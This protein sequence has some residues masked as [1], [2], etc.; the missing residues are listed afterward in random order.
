VA[1]SIGAVFRTSCNMQRI[2]IQVTRGSCDVVR[3]VIRKRIGALASFP[4]S[5]NISV[6][7]G[8][9]SV[10]MSGAVNVGV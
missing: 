2:M 8:P 10:W 4:A 7:S 9:S 5:V 3:F 6:K 1:E